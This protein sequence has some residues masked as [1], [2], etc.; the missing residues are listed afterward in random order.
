M[1]QVWKIEVFDKNWKCINLD[2]KYCSDRQQAELFAESDCDWI[3]GAH[4]E[5]TRIR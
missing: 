3:G 1:N 2:F 5:V 4:F